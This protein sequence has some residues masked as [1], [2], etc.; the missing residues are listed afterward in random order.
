[1]TLATRPKFAAFFDG[2]ERVHVFHA[3]VDDKYSG[4]FGLRKLFRALIGHSD[5]DVVVDMH[6]H[7]RTVFLRNLFKLSRIRVVVF[8]KGRKE[9]KALTRRERKVT[10]PLPHTV[11]RYKM[12]LEKAG[13]K[14][15]MT[16]APYIK[17]THTSEQELEAWLLKNRLKKNKQWIGI[18]PF[19]LH[20]S[21]IWPLANYPKL[22]ELI[23]KKLDCRLFF[24]GGGA[25]EIKYFEDV[26][27]LFPDHIT[28]VAGQMK[29]PEEI[30]LIKRLDL[31]V[32]TD[33]S[34][35]HLAVLAG[36]EVL[37]IWGGTHPDVGF[38]P[39]GRGEDS[40]IQINRKELPCIPCSVFGTETCHRGDFACMNWIT[41]E[42]I[43]ARI[44]T[45]LI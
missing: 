5:Y 23:T 4:F 8:D 25:T 16:A 31:M 30:A 40:I 33:S 41:P 26:K 3:D 13:F 34:N 43:S 10:K 20:T 35:M 37:A 7:L 44:I 29:V 21:K 14:F 9:K 28:V 39:Y 17:P 18:A 1:V 12:A 22:I 45:R 36:T 2:I 19:A 24:F 27:Q 15:S 11:D 6:D 38:G 42:M 32:C